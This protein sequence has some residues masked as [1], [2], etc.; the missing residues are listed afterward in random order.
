MSAHFKDA[1]H[2]DAAALATLLLVRS[3]HAA[4]VQAGWAPSPGG[5]GPSPLHRAN[6]HG[7]LEPHAPSRAHAVASSAAAAARKRAHA[8]A[9]EAAAAGGA[10]P[11]QPSPVASTPKAAATKRRVRLAM[12]G[13]RRPIPSSPPP[14]ISSS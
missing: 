9:A 11:P 12:S 14:E 6:S 3:V 13:A 4:S 7:A 8:A 5:G 1:I 2:A 10:P